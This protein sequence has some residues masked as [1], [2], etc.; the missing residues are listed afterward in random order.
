MKTLTKNDPEK[1]KIYFEQKMAFTLG[2]MEVQSLIDEHQEFNL[3]DVRDAEDYVEAH[4]PGA[5]CLTEENWES[6]A[7][8]SKDMMNILYSYSGAC[9]LAAQAA[10]FFASNGYSVME[11]DGGFDAWEDHDLDIETGFPGHERHPA[12]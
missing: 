3:I 8:L 2:P 5:V 4:I 1:A 10:F 12:A 7:G 11:M 6:F 9:H